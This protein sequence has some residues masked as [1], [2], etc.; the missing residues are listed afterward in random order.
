[1]NRLKTTI[2]TYDAL[3][4]VYQDKFMDF[5]LYNDTYDQFCALIPKQD[6]SI[7]EIGCGPGN[8]TRYLLRQRPDFEILGIDL[9]PN[10]VALAKQ[11]NPAAEFEVMDCREID[12]VNN[13][14]DGI[15]C[16][17]C[18]PYLSKEESVKFISDAAGLLV[19]AGILYFSFIE[20]DYE[21]SG[22]ET[23]S[24]GRYQM[25]IYCHESNY[26][27]QSLM[28]NNFEVCATI[29]KDYP[30]ADGLNAVHTIVIAKKL[31]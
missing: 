22:I 25:Y 16:G 4:Q 19:S 17:F 11:N 31:K 30:K 6:A 3:A 1:M 23:S 13:L 9:A 18:L 28:Q 5:D 27:M 26:L 21:K 2:A 7:F 12:T 10:M 24:D 14:F 20:D 8:I 29:R 15:M